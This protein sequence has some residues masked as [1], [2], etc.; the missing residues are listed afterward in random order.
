MLFF[1]H[2]DINVLCALFVFLHL[3]NSHKYRSV[4]IEIRGLLVSLSNR[5]CFL[6]LNLLRLL[7]DVDEYEG[8]T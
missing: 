4:E 1:A 5:H 8:G 6:L 3:E 2:F 7:L